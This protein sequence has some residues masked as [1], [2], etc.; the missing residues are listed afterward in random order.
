MSINNHHLITTIDH[1]LFPRPP[2]AAQVSSLVPGLAKVVGEGVSK[3][4]MRLDGMLALLAAA[5]IGGA[6][7]KADGALEKEKVRFFV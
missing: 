4:A 6:D 5:Y 1:D 2:A 7:V 3:A